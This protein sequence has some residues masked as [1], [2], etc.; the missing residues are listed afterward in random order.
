LGKDHSIV[1]DPH[2]S[3][4]QPVISGTNTTTE[5][6]MNMLKAGESPELIASIFELN[7]KDVKDV[8]AF[9]KRSAA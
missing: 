8:Q 4:G 9:M 2:H 6:I 5:A 1:V 7:R 3:F